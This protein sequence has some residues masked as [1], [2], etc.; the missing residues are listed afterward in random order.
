MKF[1][2]IVNFDTVR[3]QSFRKECDNVTQCLRFIVD[4]IKEMPSVDIESIYIRSYK[5]A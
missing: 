2:V 3:R 1:V 4:R 5:K